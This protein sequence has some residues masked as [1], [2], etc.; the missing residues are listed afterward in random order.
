M[1][2]TRK[3]FPCYNR[4]P[5]SRRRPTTNS[6]PN[7]ITVL[8]QKDIAEN[9]SRTYIIEIK[10]SDAWNSPTMGGIRESF[11]SGS[12]HITHQQGFIAENICYNIKISDSDEGDSPSP[13]MDARETSPCGSDE[14]TQGDIAE[15][16]TCDNIIEISYSDEGDSPNPTMD[17]TRETSPCGS[18]DITQ[19]DIAQNTCD[20]I[21]EMRPC[22]ERHSPTMDG[23]KETS[24]CASD[25]VTQG[26]A[27]VNTCDN[28][29]INDSESRDSPT[30]DSIN[31]RFVCHSPDM[32]YYITVN[33][34]EEEDTDGD[35]PVIDNSKADSI[36]SH[37]HGT[38]QQEHDVA[39]GAEKTGN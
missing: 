9:R 37:H 4:P 18:N 12:N 31:E 3:R 28:I 2:R 16:N 34:I 24:P 20:N 29:A 33:D 21:I 5:E 39:K 14:V 26:I 38:E 7:N 27:Q 35:V 17:G 32:D 19:G 1:D 15:N 23:T 22:D 11:T 36:S 8:T 6:R 10:P 30:M 13:T 25:D